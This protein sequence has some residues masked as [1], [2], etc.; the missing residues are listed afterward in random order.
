[1]PT[2]KHFTKAEAEA[3]GGKRVRTLVEWSGVPRGT[4]GTVVKADYMGKR[5]PAFE[6]WQDTWDVVIE[7]N[8]PEPPLAR[9]RRIRDWFPR[10][11]YERFLTEEET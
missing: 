3:K 1:M 7:W 10:W 9:R 5:K 11:E 4:T 8:L 6:D 2:E